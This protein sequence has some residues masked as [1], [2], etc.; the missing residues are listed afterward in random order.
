MKTSHF[1]PIVNPTSL[2]SLALVAAL[3]ASAATFTDNNWISMV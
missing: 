1:F 3:N 2:R